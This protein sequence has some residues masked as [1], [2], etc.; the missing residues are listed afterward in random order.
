[1]ERRD[2]LRGALL[3]VGAGTALVQLA[4]PAET[5]ALTVR[6][7]ILLGHPPLVPPLTT[8]PYPL[9]EEVYTRMADGGFVAI[10]IIT[11]SWNGEAELESGLL[12]GRIFFER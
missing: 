8:L 6:E 11:R 10:G 2:F 5:A 7:P 12:R 3:S 4:N 9:S 1:M